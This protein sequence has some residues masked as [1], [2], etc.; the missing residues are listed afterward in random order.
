MILNDN[1]ARS[2]GC[3]SGVDP[4]LLCVSMGGVFDV[5]ND[6]CTIG[7]SGYDAA[8]LCS[9]FPNEA[10]ALSSSGSGGSSNWLQQLQGFD[11]GIISNAYCNIAPLLS[12]GEIPAACQPPS[13]AP[14]MG[15]GFAEDKTP[16]TGRYILAIVLVVAVAFASYFVIK[17]IA[18]K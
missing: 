14:G 8:I 15:G 12:G 3:P 13:G 1:I 7:G 5:L 2:S 6:V 18:K 17:R 10:A 4:E 16:K 9:A 11:F